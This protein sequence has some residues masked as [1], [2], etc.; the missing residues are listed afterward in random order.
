MERLDPFTRLR[1]KLV[2]FFLKIFFELWFYLTRFNIVILHN[3]ERIPFSHT[4]RKY[5]HFGGGPQG[6][7]G[8]DN[9][10]TNLRSTPFF[11]SSQ[12]CI[13]TEMLNLLQYLICFVLGV[14][15][16]FSFLFSFWLH[17]NFNETAL[18]SWLSV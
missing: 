1:W 10:Q 3:S 6:L 12:L 17:F 8:F 4:R 14:I 13:K 18:F 7:L 9:I 11:G 2:I 15:L 16:L 5:I